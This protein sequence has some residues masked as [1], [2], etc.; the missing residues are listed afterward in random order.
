MK[1]ILVV[2]DPVSVLNAV[3]AILERADFHILQADS[4]AEAL[5][6]AAGNA[7]E[8]DLL[9]ADVQM[10]EMSG[11]SLGDALKKVR[12]RR[13]ALCLDRGIPAATSLF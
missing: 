13:F 4:G 10:P 3:N 5:K 1:T 6:L 7:G 9:L 2:E 12:R 11:P 8:I